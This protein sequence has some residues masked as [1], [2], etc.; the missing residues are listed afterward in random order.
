MEFELSSFR[1]HHN[2]SPN[3][4]M[5]LTS[6]IFLTEPVFL[7]LFTC[8]HKNEWSVPWTLG[9]SPWTLGLGGGFLR[10]PVAGGSRVW[11]MCMCL[12]KNFFGR[13]KH[14]FLLRVHM[15]CRG[16][17]FVLVSWDVAMF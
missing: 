17:A 7:D 15:R 5:Y 13:G 10:R 3:M 14:Q 8:T 4:N 16:Y 11:K 1:E 6:L 12:E 9:L 2:T